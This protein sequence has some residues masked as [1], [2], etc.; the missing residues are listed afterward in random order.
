ML[1]YRIKGIAFLKNLV[2]G[3]DL[4][5]LWREWVEV[6]YNNCIIT[7]SSY[8][9]ILHKAFPLPHLLKVGLS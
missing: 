9:Y 7:T 2:A 8:I 3:V 4:F 1:R 6:M 5:C